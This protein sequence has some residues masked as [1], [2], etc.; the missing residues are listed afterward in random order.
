M[1]EHPGSPSAGLYK[2]YINGN[3]ITWDGVHG[4][5]NAEFNLLGSGPDRTLYFGVG[6]VADA[7]K[8]ALGT[9]TN[10]C[11]PI[12]G[13]GGGGSSVGDLTFWV[14]QDLGCGNIYVTISSYGSQTISYYYSSGN[15]GCGASGSA[16]YTGLPYAAYSYNAT[17]DGGCTWSGNVTIGQSCHTIHLTL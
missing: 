14:N 8:Y 13:G 11:G 16:N 2:G 6:A 12:Q 10:T 3:T 7:G 15:P 1:C 9:W 5:P 17:S 4:L